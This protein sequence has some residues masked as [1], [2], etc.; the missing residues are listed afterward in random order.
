MSHP[1]SRVYAPQFW[2]GRQDGAGPEERSR[3]VQ[4]GRYSES[5][6]LSPNS[7]AKINLDTEGQIKL[8]RETECWM[9]RSIE[10]MRPERP[11]YI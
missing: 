10:E 7:R 4:E 8:V 5:E 1:E 9:N 11:R 3:A 6:S 2:V